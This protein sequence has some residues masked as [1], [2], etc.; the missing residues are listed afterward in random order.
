MGTRDPRVD[1]YI[2]KAA[3]FAQPVLVHLR[4]LVHEACPKVNEDLKWRFPVFEYHGMLCHMA[5]FKA[6]CAFG[7]WKEALVTGN[8]SSSG[9]AMGGFGKLT[10]VSD[11]PANKVMIQLIT[12]AMKLNEAGVKAP[13]AASKRTKVVAEVPD[14]LKTA[15]AKDAK[16]RK[17][18]EAFSPSARQEY[19]DW[20]TSAK[21]D[22]T[23][24][25][26]V[27]TAVEWMR[28]GKRRNWK[29]EKNK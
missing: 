19:I 25:T 26:R 10:A 22:E 16:A 14:D 2:A 24:A 1:A 27:T 12:K 11:L 7:F 13:S 6:H 18:F 17:T 28:E 23:R 20:I 15:L 29:Y 5:A 3:P 21:R 4:D 9:A 8:A